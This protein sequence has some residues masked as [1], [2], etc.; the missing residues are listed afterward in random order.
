MGIRVARAVVMSEQPRSGHHAP[1]PAKAAI[2]GHAIHPMLIPFPIAFLVGV[3][4]TDLAFVFTSDP[5]WA[6]ASYWLVVAGITTGLLAALPGLID[7][8]GIER[9]RR[10]KAGWIHLFGN[11]LMIAIA[12]LNWFL[13]VGD[14]IPGAVEITLSAVTAGLLAITGWYGGELAYRHLVGP[15]G[16]D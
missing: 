5:F 3:L 8:T 10:H 1:A 6:R 12:T 4:A 14:P 2:G 13:R 9:A 11:L 15:T 16:H 7:F